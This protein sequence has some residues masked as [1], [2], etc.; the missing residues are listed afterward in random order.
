MTNREIVDLYLDN[1]LI[2]T[3]IDCQF[4][5]ISDKQF[6][7]DFFNDLIL[8]LLEMDNAKMNDAHENNH[9]NTFVTRIIINNIWSSTSKYYKDYYKFQNKTR[10]ITPEDD[11]ISAD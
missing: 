1:G 7:E 11:N 9:F 8:I 4:S 5:K 3:C 2:Q 10:E 6:K